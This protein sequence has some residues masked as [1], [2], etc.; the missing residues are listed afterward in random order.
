MRQSVAFLRVSVA[1]GALAVVAPGVS[2]QEQSAPSPEVMA[3]IRAALRPALPFP[4][5]D[6]AGL[7]PADGTSTAPWMVRP[8][9]PGQRVIEVLSN[10][11]NPDQGRHA[12]KGM[13]EIQSAIEAA[14]RKADSQYEH[15]LAEVQRTG[16][17][18]DIT[19][20]TLADEGVAG[21]RIDA[22]LHLTIEVDADLHVAGGV[23]ATSI[24]PEVSSVVPGAVA[25]VSVPS[26]V[27]RSGRTDERF[28]QAERW[29]FF[30]AFAAPTVIRR[31]A[32]AF[33]VAAS[34]IAQ[35]ASGPP[36][37]RTLAV[38]L[39]GNES[40]MADVIRRADWSQVRALLP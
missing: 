35:A 28:C 29:I 34:P 17:S 7:L 30:G 39:R 23:I 16:R 12:A 25:V 36:R 15:A 3:A 18:Q 14:Q 4:D 24:E 38:R 5:S 31:G 13:A 11:L 22:D 26:N 10:P 27:Y 33:D 8:I 2:A 21:A 40:L 19:G 37:L 1:I 32:T 20:I 9:E 6:E